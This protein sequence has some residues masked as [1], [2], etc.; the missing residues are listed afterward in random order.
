MIYGERV[1]LRLME[2]KDIALKVKWI[3]DPEIRETLISDYISIAS[4]K[5]WFNKSI[6]DSQRKDFI[7]CSKDNNQAIGFTSLKA[8]DYINSRAEITMCLGEKKYWGKGLAK[9][10]RILILEY[11]FFELG[12]NKVY[13]ENWVGNEKIIGLNQGLGFKIEGKLRSDIFFKGE[14][15]DMV[16]MGILKDEWIKSRG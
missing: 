3:N 7:I 8:I 15:R 13:T 5:E 4:T 1:Y 2:E 14:F 6:T 11:A 16:I 12:L 9:E 10:T